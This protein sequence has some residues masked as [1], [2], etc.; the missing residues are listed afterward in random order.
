MVATHLAV[1]LYGIPG[2]K[3]YKTSIPERANQETCASFVN[4]HAPVYLHKSSVPVYHY[5]CGHHHSILLSS[6]TATIASLEYL[7]VVLRSTFLNVSYSYL[8]LDT[9]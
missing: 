9:D 1:Y 8:L 7:R 5:V 6:I 3:T 4:T 2:L